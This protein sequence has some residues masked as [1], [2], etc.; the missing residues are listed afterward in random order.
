MS[1]CWQLLFFGTPPPAD[2]VVEERTRTLV[3]DA[4]KTLQVARMTKASQRAERWARDP[5][6]LNLAGRIAIEF[7]DGATALDTASLFGALG[8]QP[9]YCER[10]TP[11][12]PPLEPGECFEGT[13]QLCC[14]RRLPNLSD[15]ALRERWLGDHTQVALSTQSTLGYLQNWVV[16]QGAHP[17]DGIVEE[18]FPPEASE[19]ID[20]FFNAVDDPV[21]L[22]E[23]IETMTHSTARFLALDTALVQ[24]LSDT[25]LI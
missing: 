5:L 4:V 18:Y 19:R 9:Y 15:E 21:R 2:S 16:S 10:H 3:G 12:L 23:H 11:L 17:F 1:H 25:R 22:R 8:G 14:F 20:W 24:H 7:V 6:D 13:L